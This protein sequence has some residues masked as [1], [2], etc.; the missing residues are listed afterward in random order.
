LENII[1]KVSRL[2][3]AFLG[4]KEALAAACQIF[5]ACGMMARLLLLGSHIQASVQLARLAF[6]NFIIVCFLNSKSK[7]ILL[8]QL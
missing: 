2:L 1:I 8:D 3:H 5:G 4:V 6:F 7:K